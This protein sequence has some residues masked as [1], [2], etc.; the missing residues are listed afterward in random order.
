ML[1][2]YQLID[3][4]VERQHFVLLEKAFRYALV[5]NNKYLISKI[6]IGFYWVKNSFANK[7]ASLPSA[8]ACSTLIN[9]IIGIVYKFTILHTAQ[10]N[11]NDFFFC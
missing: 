10:N 2:A 3:L 11:L 6:E 8:Q 4:Q 1:A 7:L 5:Q 9:I